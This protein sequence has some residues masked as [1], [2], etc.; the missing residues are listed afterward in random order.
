MLDAL[1]NPTPTEALLLGDRIQV[2]SLAIVGSEVVADLVA[3]GPGDAACCASW[4]VRKVFALED[5]R[6]MERSS[7]ELS[8]ISLS[9]LNGTKW[10]LVDLN[11]DQE[12]VLPDPDHDA[13]RRRPG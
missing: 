9:D 7:E 6:L 11:A 12:P 4:N 5:G 8:Q 3:Q 13:A 1:R 2:K 10:R